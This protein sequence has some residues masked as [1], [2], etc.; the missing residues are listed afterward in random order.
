VRNDLD[1]FH[2]VMDVIDRVPKLGYRA[3]YLKQLMRDKLTEHEL[4]IR[5]YGEDMPEIRNWQWSDS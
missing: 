2:R 3:A 4:Y 1:R 5:Q